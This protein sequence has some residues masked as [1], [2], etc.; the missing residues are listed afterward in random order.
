MAR[1][2]SRPPAAPPAS[3]APAGPHQSARQGGDVSGRRVG[4]AHAGRAHHHP[5]DDAAVVAGRHE[6]FDTIAQNTNV[7]DAAWMTFNAPY[8][9]STDGS[10]A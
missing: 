8:S 6:P 2:A 10:P 4:A 1:T 5:R 3:T 9:F 7:T